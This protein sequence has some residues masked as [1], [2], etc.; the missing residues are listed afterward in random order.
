LLGLSRFRV[1]LELE[2]EGFLAHGAIRV[3]EGQVPHRDFFS[4]QPPLSF[5]S[6]AAVYRLAGPSLL[7]L[8][9]FGL[10]LYL[11]IPVLV[12][13]LARVWSRRAVALLAA[14]P[15]LF[16]GMPYSHFVPFAAWQ[17]VALSLLSGTLYAWA[18]F[19][20]ARPRVFLVLSGVAAGLAL[21][22]RHDQGFYLTLSILGSGLVLHLWHRRTSA[23]GGARPGTE[24]AVLQT[25]GLEPAKLLLW[26]LAGLG[27]VGLPAVLWFFAKGA[28]PEMWRQLVVFPLTT[29]AR[30]SS[31]PFPSLRTALTSPAGS[32]VVLFYLPILFGALGLVYLLRRVARRRVGPDEAGLAFVLLWSILFYLQVLTRSDIPHLLITLTPAFV[33]FA[34]GLQRAIHELETR[35][36][37]TSSNPRRPV[38]PAVLLIVVLGGGGFIYQTRN[39]FLPRVPAVLSEVDLPRAGVL[40][41]GGRELAS[42]VRDLQQRVPPGRSMLALPYQPM[43]YFLCERRNPTRWEYLWP[44]DQSAEELLTMVRQA[45]ADPPALVLIRKE[46]E[47]ENWLGLVL[48]YVHQDFRLTGQAGDFALYLP[49][50][51]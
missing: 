20:G 37:F 51:K 42:F 29:Y 31:V 22:A 21:L 3:M 49:P 4:L 48:D 33:L 25:A 47:L 43:F 40:A 16:L 46:A 24:T 30:T 27:A 34:I 50:A 1:G 7:S 14:V 45:R 9:K 6:S 13:L 38:G 11:L 39:A 35:L 32:H 18:A 36:G 19:R 5:Y 17:G 15:C 12:F 26:W 41:E 10:F 23:A 44:G 2:D 28:I 8:R